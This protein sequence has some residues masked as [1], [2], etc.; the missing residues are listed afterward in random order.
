MREF[1]WLM[2][3]ALVQCLIC[4][5]NWTGCVVIS[6]SPSPVSTA[7]THT[8]IRHRYYYITTNRQTELSFQAIRWDRPFFPSIRSPA[9]QSISREFGFAVVGSFLRFLGPPVYFISHLMWCGVRVFCLCDYM[10]AIT[11]NIYILND[12]NVVSILWSHFLRTCSNCFS[13]RSCNPIGFDIDCLLVL[14]SA[15]LNFIH[16]R[17]ISLLLF[18]THQICFRCRLSY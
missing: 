11:V 2:L 18:L 12:N 5:R 16:V 10:R 8:H 1:C 14:P 4:L 9:L 3:G 15:S 17:L 13:A 7:R 6:V